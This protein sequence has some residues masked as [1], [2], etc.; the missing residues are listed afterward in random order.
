MFGRRIGSTHIYNGRSL[1]ALR[2]EY[3]VE[4]RV[5]V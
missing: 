1:G 3:K 2:H 4:A 5:N